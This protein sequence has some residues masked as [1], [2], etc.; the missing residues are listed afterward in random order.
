MPSSP[1]NPLTPAHTPPAPTRRTVITSATW[2][3]P[4]I[5]L[6]A[7]APA[8]ATSACTTGLVDVTAQNWAFTSGQMA[9]WDAWHS[10]WLPVVPALTQW[11]SEGNPADGD[12]LIG[13]VTNRPAHATYLSFAPQFTGGFASG[14]DAGTADVDTVIAVTYTFTAVKGAKYAW[15]LPIRWG[16]ANNGV[17]TPQGLSIGLQHSGGNISLADFTTTNYSGV[18]IPGRVA[19]STLG[20]DNAD[21]AAAGTFTAPNGGEVTF[22]L[23]FVLP[24]ASNVWGDDDAHQWAPDPARAVWDDINVG[25]PVITLTECP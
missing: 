6:A 17:K 2:A 14:S 8:Y 9:R 20:S 24:A 19:L 1:H 10:G 25:K 21:L 11:G 7:A 4:A 12:P 5:S 15:S 18:G 23:T 13:T 16:H 3:V 22:A